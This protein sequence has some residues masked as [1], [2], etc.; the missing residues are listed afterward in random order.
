MYTCTWTD[1]DNLSFPARVHNLVL[2]IVFPYKI[3]VMSRTQY[4]YDG[5]T[6]EYGQYIFLCILVSTHNYNNHIIYVH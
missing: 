2:V 1:F 3:P 6:Q 5:Y 4:W